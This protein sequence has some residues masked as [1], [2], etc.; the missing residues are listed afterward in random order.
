MKYF[1]PVKYITDI[2]M[3]SDMEVEERIYLIGE[4]IETLTAENTLEE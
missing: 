2:L 4:K 1:Y 3:D